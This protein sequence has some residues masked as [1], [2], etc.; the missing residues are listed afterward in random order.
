MI[1][2]ETC[3]LDLIE[4][5]YIREVEPEKFSPSDPKGM[6][7]LEAVSGGAARQVHF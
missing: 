2:S 3:A 7:S 1:A 6:E 4:A 5:K